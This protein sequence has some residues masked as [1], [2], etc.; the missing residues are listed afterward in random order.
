MNSFNL[1]GKNTKNLEMQNTVPVLKGGFLFGFFIF[2]L[3]M[4]IISVPILIY[5]FPPAP[6]KDKVN[7]FKKKMQEKRNKL[8]TMQE[9]KLATLEENKETS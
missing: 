8:K 4:L 7:N 1:L 2:F 5:F 6:I 9:N 3:I